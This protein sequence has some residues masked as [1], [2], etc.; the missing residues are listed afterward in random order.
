MLTGCPRLASLTLDIRTNDYNGHPRV[1]T[2][3]DLSIAG[4]GET[5]ERI[6][7]E[8]VTYLSLRGNW[9]VDNESILSQF[10]VDTFPNVTELVTRGGGNGGGVFS[11]LGLGSMMFII[12]NNPNHKW[13]EVQTDLEEPRR[14]EALEHGLCHL[15]REEENL[16]FETVEMLEI[17]ILFRD[18]NEN[19]FE[20]DDFYRV[21]KEVDFERDV[22]WAVADDAPAN[23]SIQVPWVV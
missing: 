6:V 17:K 22:S 13:Q 10:L 15:E 8:G 18:G 19:E 20:Y 11:S 7:V 9:V 14:Q 1:I 5:R 23:S 12:R 3:A 4:S 16:D 21:L 2:E